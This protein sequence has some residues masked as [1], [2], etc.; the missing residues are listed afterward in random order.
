MSDSPSNVVAM[1][2]PEQVLEDE[3]VAQLIGQGYTRAAVTDE[4]SMLATLAAIEK[5]EA[6]VEP[7]RMIRIVSF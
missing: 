1:T 4:A 7:P 3:L 5:S 6:V 2:Q